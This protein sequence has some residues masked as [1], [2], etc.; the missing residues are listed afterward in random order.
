MGYQSLERKI[1]TLMCISIRP[2]TLLLCFFFLLSVPTAFATE[3]T[4]R[5]SLSNQSGASVA[6]EDVQEIEVIPI[7][8]WL[9]LFWLGFTQITSAPEVLSPAIRLFP[10]LG[11]FKRIGRSNTFDNLNREKL[12]GFIKSCPGTYFSEIIKDTGLNRGTVRYHLDILETQDMIESYKVKG[13]IRYFLNGSTYEKKDKVVIA[14]L[15]NDM[16]RRIILEILNGRCITHGM[17]VEKFGVSAPT[18]SWHIRHLKEQG[19]VQADRE[20]SHITYSIDSN[21]LKSMQK[22]VNSIYS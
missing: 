13:K 21:Y 19:I 11:G 18:I 20:D 22:Y 9:F 14:A 4:I 17:L 15:R 3:Y 6:G 8:Y 7:P 2:R 16:D 10:V 1:T 12:Y 5:P